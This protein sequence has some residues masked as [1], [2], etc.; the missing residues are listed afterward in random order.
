[1]NILQDNGQANLQRA[2]W[3]MRTKSIA[4]ELGVDTLTV[5]S[6]ALGAPIPLKYEAPLR[7]LAEE[8]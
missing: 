7:R 2:L 8:S 5:H 4:S 1:M 3:A 6:W